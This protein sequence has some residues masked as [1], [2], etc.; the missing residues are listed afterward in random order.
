MT[1]SR[2]GTAVHL[3]PY[4]LEGI[5]VLKQDRACGLVGVEESGPDWRRPMLFKLPRAE[6]ASCVRA[7]RRATGRRTGTPRTSSC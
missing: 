3:A 6:K 7:T 5:G 4:L 2:D 1:G